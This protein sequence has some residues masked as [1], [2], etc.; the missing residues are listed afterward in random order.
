MKAR[1]AAVLALALN[2]LRGLAVVAWLLWHQGGLRL[3]W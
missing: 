2:E 1:H 3:P